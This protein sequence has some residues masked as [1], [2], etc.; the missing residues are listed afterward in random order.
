MTDI[1]DLVIADLVA[2]LYNQPS[3]LDRVINIDKV[4]IGIKE[5]ADAFIAI[6]RGSY[7]LLDWARDA[8]AAAITED[9]DIGVVPLGFHIGIPDAYPA[10][11][12]PPDKPVYFGGHSLGA[13]HVCQLAGKAIA[14]GMRNIAKIVLFGCPNP[15]GEKLKYILSG[16]G[17]PSYKNLTDPVTCVPPELLVKPVREFI[18][19]SIAPPAGD[20]LGIFAP[21]RFILYHQGI[22]NLYGKSSS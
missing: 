6:G 10:L 9:P 12:L 2:D 13:G 18:P 21:H 16:T 15:G 17:I 22:Q 5:T 19:L 8:A 14:R 3:Q 7:T 4:C 1:T 20:P 11:N